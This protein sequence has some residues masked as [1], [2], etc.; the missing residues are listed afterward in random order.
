[1]LSEFTDRE[2]ITALGPL[3][4]PELVL[5]TVATVLGLTEGGPDPS[6]RRH[7]DAPPEAPAV[8][9]VNR[10]PN[11]T[12]VDRIQRLSP[13]DLVNFRRLAGVG[14]VPS[15]RFYRLVQ[16]FDR[17]PTIAA[18]PVPGAYRVGRAE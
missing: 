15:V 3:P 4:D 5:H 11:A 14:S 17:T 2:W 7:G 12:L 16:R 10:Y 1:L 13:A 18:F 6:R 9:A 8:P